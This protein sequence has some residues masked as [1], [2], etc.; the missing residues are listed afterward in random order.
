MFRVELLAA[1]HGDGIWIEYGDAKKP[2]RILLDGGPAGAYDD[3]NGLRSR[4][5]KAMKGPKGT[6]AFELFVI[7][8][9]DAD[10]ID[11]PLILLRDKGVNCTFKDIW[12]NGSKQIAPEDDQD[13]FGPLQGEFLTSLLGDEAAA[14]N[15]NGAVKSKAVGVPDEGDLPV[16][17]LPGG[18]R[19][20][21]LSP[22][23]R[24]L[25]R[26][27]ARWDAAIRDFTPGDLD[28]ARRR[29]EARRDYEPPDL[30]PI[31]GGKT[32]GSDRTPAN[33]SSIALLAEFNGCAV[34]LGADAHARVLEAN[35]RRLA[36]QRKVPA[37]RLD[38]FKLPHHGS[39]ANLTNGVLDTVTCSRFL[40][41]T[42]GD[43]FSHPDEETVALILGRASAPVELGF[44]YR[45]PTTAPFEGKGGSRFTTKYG[46]SGRLVLD[47]KPSA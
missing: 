34:L 22:G 40:F 24:E 23:V 41:S 13:L 12:F 44:N 27:R 29:L 20:T 33:G 6:V 3:E 43:R 15:W 26:L 31:F 45:S 25:R 32:P 17:D 47:V 38:A 14:R 7:T 1:A 4:V 42:N 18:M 30:P 21:V 11:V 28:E 39:I 9:I 5:A 2:L 19:L 36:I 16:F 37:I 35:L 8:H 10:H 46:D